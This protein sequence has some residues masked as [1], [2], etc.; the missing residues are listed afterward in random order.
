MKATR[1][2]QVHTRMA[3][4]R[5][6]HLSRVRSLTWFVMLA[7]G[8]SPVAVL[9]DAA[10]APA[11][12]TPAPAPA[13]GAAA[14][15]FSSAFTGTSQSV[16]ISRFERGNP[17]L[18]G[19]YNVDVFVNEGRVARKDITFRAV[20][21]REA[22]TPCFDYA[23]LVQMGVDTNRFDPQAVNAQS[24]CV[25]VEAISA[26]ATARMDVGELRLDVSIP[27]EAL[28]RQARG[29]V[30][31]EL[32][33]QGETA[34]LLGYNF[35]AYSLNQS[36]SG[37]RT[38]GG[39]AATGADG[40]RVDVQGPQYYMPGPGGTYVPS[41]TG[42]YM[43]GINGQY[44]PVQ[45]GTFVPMQG[46]GYGGNDV[47]AYLGLNLG[48]NVMGWRFRSQ[49]TAQWDRRTGRT[50][51]TN[52]NATATH[53]ITR[54]KAQFT[55]GDGYTQGVVFD[56]TPF[57]G[58]TLYSDDRMLPDSQ[59]GYAP[60]VRGTA[61]TQARVEVRQN[62][63][64]LYQTAVAPGPFVI[65]DLYATG[66]GGDL[67]VSVFEADGSVHG[68]VVPYSAVP[69][70]LR[71]G[72]SRWAITDGQV[73]N[74]A[75]RNEK[76]YFV[77]GTYQRGINN[78]LTVYGGTQST[79]RDL[80]HA[81]LGGAAIN[82]PVGAF[83]L[84]VTH[85]R[86]NF[87]GA[88]SL[89]GYSTRISYSKAIP[90]SG[91]TFALA[92]YRYSNGNF[93]SLSDAVV[94]QDMMASMHASSINA[95]YLMR[96]KQRLNVTINQNFG[97]KYGQLYF[98]GSRNTYWQNMPSATTYQ[99]GYSNT[100]RRVNF[101]LTASRT[102]AA[103]PMYNGSRYDTQFGINLSIPLGGPSSRNAA[104]LQLSATH[105]DVMGS[106]DRVGMTG[107][108]GK[109]S[110][111]SY[112]AN[113][114]YTDYS[115][116][117]AQTNA[118]ATLAWQ[119]PYANLNGGYSYSDHYQQASVSASGGVVVHPGGITLAS[120]VDPGSAIGIIEAPDAKGARVSS[121]GQTKVDGRGYAVASNL[122]PYRMNDVTL[123]PEGTSKDVELQTTRL[124]VAPRAGAVVPLKFETVRGRAVLIHATRKDGAVVPFGADVLDADGRSMGT[125]GQAGQLF[126]R[127]AEEGGVLTVRWGSRE[128]EKCHV[129]YTLPARSKSEASEIA[130]TDAVCR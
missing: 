77:E 107:T 55:I 49:E 31:P 120:Q 10:E 118:S 89:S 88:D 34:F 86:T 103:G 109:D 4:A 90:T 105:D 39:G 59:Q 82:T 124:Q 54:W 122:I 8:V 71:P 2:N 32:W 11:G 3:Q 47:D 66:Y 94:T 38:S 18:P 108:F 96:S 125:V 19:S 56:T 13:T 70:L 50:R 85:S 121:S 28:R 22:A 100:Y 72:I 1:I 20:Q 114:A 15:E 16:D 73:H 46:V 69:M 64:L 110:E 12:P 101:G 60:V 45:R 79:Y 115:N 93:L 102:Y 41:A 27:Q 58:I 128:A 67:T 98:N 123:D 6:P 51:W 65:D 42:S 21:G 87:K 106:N 52:I 116:A 129:Q 83:A 63:N 112:G 95:I 57:R 91:T 30:T 78:W 5:T 74:T 127:G 37:P 33:D 43:L 9:A 76:P 68:F 130:A 81:Y 113:V 48:M 23:T 92:S 25:P 35:N 53:D 26:D 80:Y 7:L 29:Y 24:V 119:A 111:F 97:G 84:D 44:V 126:V 17:V 14:V 62:G 117:G 36:Y 61:N 75:L 40:S 104:M 99:L